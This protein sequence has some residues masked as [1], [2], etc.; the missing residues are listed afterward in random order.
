MIYNT[1]MIGTQVVGCVP[2]STADPPV[3]CCV[4]DA[5]STPPIVC[6]ANTYQQANSGTAKVISASSATVAYAVT[7]DYLSVITET[8][9]PTTTA[10]V[11][12]QCVDFDMDVYP[13]AASLPQLSGVSGGL[14]GL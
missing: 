11:C 14:L 6:P 7:E 4:P 10:N 13:T 3:V 8:A 2:D 5:T 12:T 9:S 1:G